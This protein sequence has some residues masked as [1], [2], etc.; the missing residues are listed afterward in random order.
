MTIYSREGIIGEIKKAVAEG[1][2]R[3]TMHV[4]QRL[5]QRNISIADVKTAI[6]DGELIEH[7]PE[8]FPHPSCLILGF[9]KLDLPLHVVCGVTSEDACIITAYVPSE[10]EWYNNYTLRKGGDSK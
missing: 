9:P 8:D 2:I 4:L 6:A 3:W 1:R 7:Y 10:E 5:Q